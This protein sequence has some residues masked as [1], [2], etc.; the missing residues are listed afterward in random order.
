M[1]EEDANNDTTEKPTTISTL[2]NIN[3]T[4]LLAALIIINH[5]NISP[6]T[7]KKSAILSVF[8]ASNELYE[9]IISIKN[10]IL[11]NTALLS[12]I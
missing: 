1:S 10:I 12:N 2:N 8:K 4:V 5:K 6:N 11:K 3:K 9:S 7:V